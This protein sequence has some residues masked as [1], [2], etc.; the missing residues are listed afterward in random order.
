MS[1]SNRLCSKSQRHP[2][3]K[4]GQRLMT[5]M[6]MGCS[7]GLAAGIDAARRRAAVE[8]ADEGR[9]VGEED[10]HLV[11]RRPAGEDELTDA[12]GLVLVDVLG[13]LVIAADDAQRRTAA[14][15][16]GA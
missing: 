6:C 11:P 7:S 3:E 15:G 4:L 10:P 16:D 1:W 12:R 8:V 13:H 9:H 5:T 14:V 2:S